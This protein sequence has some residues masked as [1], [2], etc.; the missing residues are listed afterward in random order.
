MRIVPPETLAYLQKNLGTEPILII[1][2]EWTEGSQEILYS[3]Q[4]IN[5]ADYPYPTLIQIS[6][7]DTALMV[8]GAGDSQSI[9]VT[10][11][12]VDGKLKNIFNNYDIHKRTA[13]VYHYFRGLNLENKFLVFQGEINSPVTWHE[14]GRNLSFTIL[15]HT[16]DAEVAFSMEEGDFPKVPEEALGEVWPLVFGQVCN[17]Q[18]IKVRAPRRS[19]L[20]SGEGWHD[21]TIEPRLCQVRYVQCPTVAIGQVEKLT[22]VDGGYAAEKEWEYGPD[23]DCVDDRF[24]AICNLLSQLEQELVYEH[25]P[26]N[27]RGGDSF[28]QNEYVTLNVNGARLRGKFSGTYFNVEDREHPKYAEW[29]HIPCTPVRDHAYGVEKSNW[30]EDWVETATGSAWYHDQDPIETLEDCKPE[31]A[32]WRRIPVGGSSE[33]WEKYENMESAGFFWAPAGTEVFLEGEAEVLYV[34]SLIPGTVDSVAAY[35]AMPSGRNLLMEIPTEYYT[36]YETDYD[37]YQVVEI[38]LEKKLSLYDPDWADDI[39]VSFT[40]DVGPNPVDII[41]WLLNKYTALTFDT[42][43][44]NDVKAKLANYP[45]NF[46]VKERMNILALI[47]DIAYQSRCATYIRNGVVYI[48]YLSEEPTPVRTITE[49]DIVTGTF[50]ISITETENIITKHII[51]WRKTGAAVEESNRTD[52]KIILKHNVPKYGISEAGW[53]YYTQ[54]TFDTVL[55]SAT[56]WLIRQSHTWKYVEFSTPLKHLD[57]DLFDC[58]TLDVKQFSSAPV[59]V[60]I[61]SAAYEPESNTI[62]FKC[63]TPIL[64]GTDEVYLWAWP[65][66]QDAL[67]Q[68]PLPEEIDQANSGYA[69]DV[70]PPIGHI[71]RSGYVDS[72]GARIIIT[73]GDQNPSDLDDVLPTIVCDISDIFELEEEDP[74]FKALK[75]ARATRDRV[76]EATQGAGSPPGGGGTDSEEL[77][78]RTACGA[79]SSGRDCLY[80]VTVLYVAPD[81]VTSGGI[82]GTDAHPCLGGPCTKFVC[83]GVCTGRLSKW[84][85][86]FGDVMAALTFR[87]AKLAEIDALSGPNCGYCSGAVMKPYGVSGVKAIKGVSPKDG[88]PAPECDDIPDVPN[89]A[90]GGGETYQPKQA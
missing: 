78:K 41:E 53:N 43:T 58:I 85:H 59:K 11:D 1:G 46:Y 86:T 88:A 3:D 64:S 22:P 21:F 69:F 40:S 13:K 29:E 77:P 35:R 10:L 71:L 61:E 45:C 8:S 72:G 9:D 81:L 23:L 83:G 51:D 12:D 76:N 18:A 6:G 73:S 57:L 66:L 33:S 75:L 60:I 63:W 19:Y 54:N 68:F 15:T 42:V 67:K 7:F 36:T 39:Y 74:A 55:K 56:F 2:I 79:Q 49:S 47:R 48:K 26:I 25:N 30:N 62:R 80:E 65:A 5:G 44:F 27:I 89:P 37:G 82:S 34:V 14:G 24:E 32:I 4:R 28:P 52:L 31:N 50:S 84:C 70:T 17:M 90:G 20:T 87:M 38:G 16:E